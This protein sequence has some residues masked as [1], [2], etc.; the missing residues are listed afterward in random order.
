MRNTVANW[1]KRCVYLT[2][3]KTVS[4]LGCYLSHRIARD[5]G[6]EL[7]A[8]RYRGLAPS[9][10]LVLAGKGRKFAMNTKRRINEAGEQI[11]YA[12]CDSLQSHVTKLYRDAGIC[13][14]SSHSGRRSFASNLVE[15]G[16]EIETVQQLLV[17]QN[18]STSG[19][20]W[21]CPKESFGRCFAKYYESRV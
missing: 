17:M 8:E 18:W 1:E 16:H 6:T 11:D 2:H 10:C 3:P 14:G 5:M 15:Q 7:T 21:P 12:A 4:A 9:S 19:P 13:G 20:I